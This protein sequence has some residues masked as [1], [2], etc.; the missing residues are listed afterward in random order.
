ME[1]LIKDGVKYNQYDFY[2]KESEFEKF[3]FAQYRHLFGDSAILFP[4][5]K[6]KTETGMGTIPDG[7][8]IDFKKEKWFIIEVEI[9]NHDVYA[10]ITPQ[11]IKFSSTLNNPETRRKLIKSFES[12]V[13]QDPAKVL[14]LSVN[15][16]SET[17][18]AVTE[19]ISKEPELIII[20]EQPH[21]E[22]SNVSNR[23]PF[24]TLINV[25]RAFCKE[26]VEPGVEDIFQIEPLYQSEQVVITKSEPKA[27]AIINGDKEKDEIKKVEKRIPKWFRSPK[28]ANS[29]ILII[30]MNLL[31]N[32]NAVNFKDLENSCI[33][34]KGFKGHYNQMKN[35]GIKNHGK[36]FEENNYEIASWEPVKEFIVNEFRKAKQNN[37]T[38]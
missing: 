15:G 17:F 29:Q 20:I 4:K 38:G 13:K 31:G 1:I 35:L 2:G 10:H 22:L 36:V 27:T 33:D 5:E 18:K 24:Q 6:I 14:L 16:Q 23:L 30:Y 11:V 37:Y 12:Q 19:I 28:Q 32:K 21:K 34:I 7:F 9:S 3:V 25:F 8:V 26:G